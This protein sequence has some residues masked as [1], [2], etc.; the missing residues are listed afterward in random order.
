MRLPLLRWVVAVAV[1]LHNQIHQDRRGVAA[2]AGEVGSAG[3]VAGG[4]GGGGRETA[5]V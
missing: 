2:G 1:L 4:G 3:E 5:T